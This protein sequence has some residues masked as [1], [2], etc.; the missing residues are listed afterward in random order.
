MP[1]WTAFGAVSVV[2]TVLVLALTR[3]TQS[4]LDAP[5]KPSPE[6][7][8]AIEEEPPQRRKRANGLSLDAIST[9]ALFVNVVG[10]QLL[11]LLFLLGGIWYAEVSVSTLGV[12]VPT[13]AELGLGTALGAVLFGLNQ[14]AARLGRQFGL[15]GE[16]TANRAGATGNEEL[17]EALAPESLP[18][19]LALLFVVLPVVAVFEELL[20]RGA[21]IGGL[22]AGFGLSPWLLVVVSSLAF[23]LG[24]GAQGRVGVVVTALL[25]TALGAAFV[26][27]GSLWIVV[28]AHYLMNALEFVVC[29]GLCGGSAAES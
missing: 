9:G 10:T 2:L 28:V 16:D 15:G 13:A 8:G 7:P 18:G 26:A 5:V 29:E 23:G 6:Q 22:A 4:A 24:H 3:A 12:T 17:R 1:D 25:G 20:F 14:V 11:F 27:T 21:L 19:W